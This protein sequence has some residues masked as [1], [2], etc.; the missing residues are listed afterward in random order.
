MSRSPRPFFLPEPAQ[1]SN[2]ASVGGCCAARGARSTG[3]WATCGAELAGIQLAPVRFIFLSPTPE[4]RYMVSENNSVPCS[5]CTD[6]L[7]PD[8]L[9]VRMPPPL[10]VLD[11]PL[12]GETT[13]W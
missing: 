2:R 5:S 6:M 1:S 7:Q 8:Q 11:P 10:D 12:K 13:A 4:V 3:V 9:C